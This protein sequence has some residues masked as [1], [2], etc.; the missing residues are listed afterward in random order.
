MA[1][2][3]TY[4]DFLKVIDL[5]KLFAEDGDELVFVLIGPS[6]VV[7]GHAIL[8]LLFEL[9]VL[10]IFVCPLRIERS[11][12]GAAELHDGKRSADA[13]RIKIVEARRRRSV[14]EIPALRTKRISQTSEEPRRISL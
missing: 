11:L 12:D 3:A 2:I 7:F 8:D 1:S 9:R 6:A 14:G 4:L 5:V 10:E 13:R